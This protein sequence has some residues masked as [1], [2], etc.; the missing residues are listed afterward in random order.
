MQVGFAMK[1]RLIA[2]ILSTCLLTFAGTA[3]FVLINYNSSET[4]DP[5]CT[6]ARTRGMSCLIVASPQIYE[7]G[8]FVNISDSKAPDLPIPLSSEYLF[9]DSCIL[10]GS[11]ISFAQFKDD[12][13]RSV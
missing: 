5:V 12:P 1:P 8:A 13:N 10:A 9:S 3:V 7:K 2:I 6:F 4:S 11:N